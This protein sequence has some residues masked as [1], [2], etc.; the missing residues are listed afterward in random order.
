MGNGLNYD[1][2]TIK[3]TSSADEEI[4]ERVLD[5][6][7]IKLKDESEIFANVVYEYYVNECRDVRKLPITSTAFGL[8]ANK[9]KGLMKRKTPKGNVFCVYTED[10]TEELVTAVEV[11]RGYLGEGDYIFGKTLYDYYAKECREAGKV[12]INNT[13]FANKV[14]ALKV[15]KKRRTSKG[16]VYYL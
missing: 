15:F 7:Y 16:I 6:I 5:E 3:Y 14:R 2:E 13:M 10:T 4:I 1:I 12:P 8:R 11:I 9:H